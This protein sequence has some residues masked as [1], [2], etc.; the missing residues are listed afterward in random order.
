MTVDD[1][2]DADQLRT[3]VRAWLAQNWSGLPKSTNP[4]VSSPEKVAW[5][6]KVLEEGYAVPTFP[7]EWFGRG[8]PNKLAAVIEQEF[9][10]AKAPG[11]RQD[12]YSIPANTAL[13]FGTEQLKNDLVRDFLTE[14][15]R[16]CLLYSEPGAGSDLAAVR[17]TAVRDGDEWVVNG[18]KVWTSGATT[19]EYALLIARTDWDVPK[20]K[21]L[22]FFMIPMRQPG[23]EVRPLVQITGESHFNEVFIT[24]ARVSDAYLLGGEG[25]GWKVLQTALA[26]ERSIMGDAGRGSRN[27][28]RADDLIGLARDHG[29][30]EDP[31]VRKDL[32]NVL[33]LRELNSLN[34]ARAKA[35]AAQGTSSSVMSLGKLAMSSILHAE[36]RLKTEIIGAEALFAGPEN[37]E[38][39]DVN[40]L[41]LNAFFTSIGGGTDQIQRN[42]IGERVLGLAKEPEVD[43]DIPFRQARRS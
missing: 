5:L 19:A 12:K 20:H 40:F 25:N 3:E 2:P 11:A 35:A 1:L 8:Y 37:P 28:T 15:I 41:T 38:A 9:R 31:A 36:A 39:D 13:K 14:R 32:A 43:R 7:T 42:I 29:R 23:I 21:G 22:S 33:A 18:Q 30:L 34:N 10:A 24:D 27:R 26:Y 6:E 4:W 17:T 16:T